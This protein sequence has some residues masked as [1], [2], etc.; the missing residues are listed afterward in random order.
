MGSAYVGN[1]LLEINC[2]D[3]SDENHGDNGSDNG[4]LLVKRFSLA[5]SEESF[6]TSGDCSGKTVG[7]TVLEKYRHYKKNGNGNKYPAENE[8]RC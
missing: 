4:K 3:K 6:G 7:F 2:E 1:I 8:I 5:L